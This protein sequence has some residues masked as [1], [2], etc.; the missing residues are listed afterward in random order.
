MLG[1]LALIA[2]RGVA[3]PSDSTSS[4]LV[5]DAGGS[6]ALVVEPP[7]DASEVAAQDRSIRRVDWRNHDYDGWA[8]RLHEGVSQTDVADLGG[9]ASG[10]VT[11]TFVSV[12]FGDLDGDRREEAA[13]L[14]KQEI[15]RSTGRRDVDANLFVLAWRDRAPTII[16]SVSF[17]RPTASVRIE[18]GKV[19]VDEPDDG[20]PCSRRM[21]LEG[22]HLLTDR[23][24]CPR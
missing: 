5:A 22:D 12:A 18:D 9:G 14:L 19:V 13:V 24:M 20:P 7:K 6:A 2:C 16:A 21:T 4:V 23:P 3:A 11:T 15:W 17:V 1:G 8:G 10:R